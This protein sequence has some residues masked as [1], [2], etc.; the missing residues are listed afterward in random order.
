MIIHK[1]QFYLFFFIR[2]LVPCKIFSLK[3]D[4]KENN[5]KDL[6]GRGGGE[7]WSAAATAPGNLEKGPSRHA[8]RCPGAA[9]VSRGSRWPGRGGSGALLLR[10]AGGGDAHQP[11]RMKTR[12]KNHLK[13]AESGKSSQEGRDNGITGLL[14][15]RWSFR[16]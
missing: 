13:A 7:G 4:F 16:A 10:G 2:W 15:A 11:C 1:S 5:Q 6:R 8:T 12:R 9:A 3:I 14:S